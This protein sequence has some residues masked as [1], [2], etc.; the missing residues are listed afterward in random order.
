MAGFGG[1]L[2]DLTV[3]SV[4]PVCSGVLRVTFFFC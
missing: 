1:T 4:F 2:L 3:C